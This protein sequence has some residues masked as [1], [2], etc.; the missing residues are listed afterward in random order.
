[1]VRVLFLPDYQ[2]ALEPAFNHTTQSMTKEEI[3]THRNAPRG[4]RYAIRYFRD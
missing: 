4:Q 1:M 3:E 2:K